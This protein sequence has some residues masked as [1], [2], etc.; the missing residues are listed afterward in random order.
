MFRQTE[1]KF[2]ASFSYKILTYYNKAIYS[3]ITS[4]PIHMHEWKS[5]NTSHN[6]KIPEKF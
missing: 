1:P 5:L 6:L 2:A 4:R 3:K